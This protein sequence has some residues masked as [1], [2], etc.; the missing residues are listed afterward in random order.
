MP[1]LQQWANYY[2][3]SED[4]E[5]ASVVVV[6]EEDTVLLELP[7]NMEKTVKAIV[8]WAHE[9]SGASLMLMGRRVSLK[10]CGH[11]ELMSLRPDI[12]VQ[13]GSGSWTRKLFL[14]QSC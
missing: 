13:C 1:D 12:S 14:F 9:E 4:E 7:P 8:G 10:L 5:E 3:S 11:A 6:E 2:S